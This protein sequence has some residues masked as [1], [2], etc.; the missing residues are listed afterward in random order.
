[1][2]DAVYVTVRDALVRAGVELLE[3]DGL[4]SL[5]LRR[6][7]RE[8]GVSHGAPRRYFPTYE[9]LLGAIARTGVE[10]LDGELGPCFEEEDPRIAI[11]KAAE[12]YLRF[13][14]RR[15]EM[16]ELIVRHDLLDGAG[17]DFRDITGGWFDRLRDALQRLDQDSDRHRAAALWAGVH[18]LATLTS[19]RTVEAVSSET[20]DPE[21]SLDRLLTP[22]LG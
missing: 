14:R 11:R 15:P 17:G 9:S 18:G 5:T 7:A 16:F 13:A 6:V 8:A 21:I 2:V 1:M 10:E 12:T 3:A 22:L 4:S 19:R 20:V